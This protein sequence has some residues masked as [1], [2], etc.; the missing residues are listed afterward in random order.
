MAKSKR[1][2]SSLD[3]TPKAAKP[4]PMVRAD[5]LEPAAASIDVAP[6]SAPS[7][8][9][10]AM[11]PL[12]RGIELT[13]RPFGVVV[14]LGMAA[15]GAFRTRRTLVLLLAFGALTSV[16]CRSREI[17]AGQEFL[18]GRL[19]LAAQDPYCGCLTIRNQYAQELTLTSRFHGVKLG[20]RKLNKGEVL[21]FRYDWAAEESEDVYEI[22]AKDADRKLNMGDPKVITIEE[23]ACGTR[24]DSAGA[25]TPPNAAPRCYWWPCEADVLTNCPYGDLRLDL[26]G[27]GKR[28]SSPDAQPDTH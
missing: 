24:S 11:S 1:A 7:V 8:P 12:E 25:R 22:E 15:L 14:M 20:E 4:D 19:R 16:S 13:S 6:V 23:G 17:W 3:R 10:R 2:K 9:T 28:A 26:G 21:S 27:I 18:D 5:R